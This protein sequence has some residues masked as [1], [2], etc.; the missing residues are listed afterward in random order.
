M[1]FPEF[2]LFCIAAAV[3]LSAALPE[4]RAL[5]LTL[6]GGPVQ[7]VGESPR[8][9]ERKVEW[10]PEKTA[11]I[12]CD[13][14]DKHWCDGAT[15]RVGEMAPVMNRVIQAA[16]KRGV[17]IIHAPS[18]T[19]EFYKDTSQRRRAKEAPAGPAYL[20][21]ERPKPPPLPIDDSDGGCDS[22][23]KPW[24]RAWTR[25]HPAIK[26]AREDA[27]TDSGTEVLNL[28]DHRG[29]ENV[30]I[31]GVHTNMCVLNRPFAIRALLDLGREVVLMRDL[32]DA[33]YNPAMPPNVTH[34]R[35][36]ELVIEYIEKHH[37]P[38]ITSTDFTNKPPFRFRENVN[39][40]G[41]K[42]TKGF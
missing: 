31:M 32:T 33:M 38:T 23:Q 35:G 7:G 14:W 41:S 29:I 21:A 3:S 15:R 1:R 11:I 34:T 40:E 25:Q 10:A 22:G 17:F 28:L 26:I 30:I 16:R 6:R 9:A 18:E 27:I 12:I 19:M 36:T 2:A 13:M 42:D 39:H 20:M 5:K 4:K 37:C 24:Y 8:A